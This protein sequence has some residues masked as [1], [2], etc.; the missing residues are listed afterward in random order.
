MKYIT[1]FEQQTAFDNAKSTLDKPNMSLVTET[2][3]V[4]SLAVGGGGDN[5]NILMFSATGY[6]LYSEDGEYWTFE[7]AGTEEYE[8]KEYFK[9]SLSETDY[10]LAPT[11][12]ITKVTAPFDDYYRS[13]NGNMYAL[14]EDNWDSLYG[15][16]SVPENKILMKPRT[17]IGTNAN[18]KGYVDLGLTSGTLWATC[19]VGATS[20]TDYGSYFQWGDTVDKRDDVCNWSSYKY[21]NGSSKTLTKYNVNSSYGTVDNKITLDPEDDA[22][23][24]NMEGDWRMPTHALIE[25]L[26]AETDSEWVTGYN[27]SGVNGRKFTAS[28]GNSIF[29]PAA[30][31]RSDSSF[32][33]QGS[34]GIVWS[35]SLY[36][37]S[38]GQ[39]RFLYFDSNNIVADDGNYRERGYTVRGIL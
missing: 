38:P 19:N 21:C 5:A 37:S 11:R 8:G 35:S 20:E 33:Y 25:E 36:S 1:L 30:G 22:A 31:Q 18:G 29:I 26:V 7:Y 12:N 10:I 32:I 28:N 13:Y 34:D 6:Q 27:G 16:T 24:A 2:G 4:Y 9:Y 3:N 23:R 17:D 14:L 15:F 39:S